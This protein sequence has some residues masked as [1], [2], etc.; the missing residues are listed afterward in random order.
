VALSIDSGMLQYVP[1]GSYYEGKD[2][3]FQHVLD[4][5]RNLFNYDRALFCLT[6]ILQGTR[7]SKGMMTHMLLSNPLPQ[8]RGGDI[9]VDELPADFES[10]ILRYNL[11]KETTPRA[12]KNLLIL[13]G[14]EG[15]V[16]PSINN[17]KTRKLIL[18]Y[19]FD[20]SPKDTDYLAVNYKGKLRRLVR[21]ALGKQNLFKI[22]NGNERLFN[23]YIGRYQSGAQP[24]ILHLFNAPEDAWKDKVVYNYPLIDKYRKM[25]EAAESGDIGSFKKLMKGMPLTTAMG[26]RNRYKLPI[27]L[28]EIYE[29]ST[30]SKKQSLQMQEASKR[31]G[32]K[33]KVD[34]K[35]Q[36]L[37]DLWKMFYLQILKDKPSD[38][39]K[40]GE[41]IEEKAKSIPTIDIG[42]CTVIV[43]AS[44]SMFGSDQRP[45]HPFLTALCVVS[46]LEN[47]EGV[48]Y[49]G[50]STIDKEGYTAL[51][52][53]NATDLWRGLT[54]AISFGSKR[55]VVVSDGYENSIKGM[56]AKVYEHFKKA[57]YDFELLHIN[58]VFASDAKQGTTRVL[59]EGVKPMPVGDYRY[60]E[61]EIIFNRMIEN[62]AMVKNLLTS[63]FKKLIGE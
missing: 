23:K 27:D 61:T 8:G 11:A 56:F 32:A 50:G 57:G 3:Q 63:K 24:V 52:P 51:L 58:P 25:R 43:D 38:L 19:I 21:H 22:L 59:A 7:F 1:K 46:A 5:W 31:A 39:K 55:I 47:V 40:I 36:D 18:G 16:A 14:S 20:R 49:V 53:S 30:V 26:F 9:T 28:S 44:H 60:L 2:V 33:I 42:P 35:S 54:Q 45:M 15:E 34:Y 29:K 6:M 12:L 62:T 48:Y 4:M 17:A 13:T 37:Y 10:K 41:A